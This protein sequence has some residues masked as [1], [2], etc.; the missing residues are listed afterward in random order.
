LHIFKEEIEVKTGSALW[1]AVLC[2][3][4]A[5]LGCSGGEGST[6]APSPPPTPTY[7]IGGNVTGLT[8]SLALRDNGTDDLSV[9]ANGAFTFKTALL[10]AAAY[11]V[12]VA[13]QPANQSCSVANGTGTVGSANV[14]NVAVTCAAALT[15]AS[16]TLDTSFGTGGKVTTD[17]SGAPPIAAAKSGAKGISKISPKKVG[18][19]S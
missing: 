10:S 3:P 12:T 5:L 18:G 19:G 15:G 8:G 9:N 2:V 16:G 14:T 6:P 17:F 4:I 1:R 11:A 7:T 13:T